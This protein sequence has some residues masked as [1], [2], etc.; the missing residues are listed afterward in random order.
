[1]SL[2]LTVL[3]V[4]DQDTNFDYFRV[5][6]TRSYNTI[7][8]GLNGTDAIEK[9]RL[10]PEIGLVLMDCNMPE[11]NGL[12]ATR[13]IR[14]FNQTVPI[15]MITAYA[16]EISRQVAVTAGCNDCMVKPVSPKDL[17]NIVEKYVEHNQ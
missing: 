4:D 16:H 7:L 14:K 8:R 10:N 6:L 12:D 15:I 17:L 9:M 2:D 5:V 13:E 1:M 3:I 11:M